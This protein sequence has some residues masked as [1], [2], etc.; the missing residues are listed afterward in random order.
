MIIIKN[1]NSIEKMK[2]A[3]RLLSEL[4]VGIKDLVKSGVSTADLDRWIDIELK[5]RDLVTKTKGYMGYQHSSCISINDEVVHGMPKDSKILKDNDLVK[6]DICASW[7]GYCADMARCFFVGKNKVPHKI[8]KMVDV[9]NFALQVGVEKAVVGGRLSDI[10]NAVQQVVEKEGF[11]VVRDFAGH[12][13]GKSMHE[14]PEIL[15]YG[16]AGKGPVLRAGMTF[17][18]EPMITEG[19][20]SVYVDEDGWTVKTVDKGWAAHVE[21]TILITDNGPIF[22]TRQQN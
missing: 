3:G 21:D 4:F 6:I 11:G 8:S 13:I 7:K 2:T 22:L 12:G 18:I 20:Y 5:K 1:K 19:N 16:K 10:S 14:E 17:A 15:N 9:A